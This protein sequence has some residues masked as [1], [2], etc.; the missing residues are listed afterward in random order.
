MRA[1]TTSEIE[2]ELCRRSLGEF[3][4]RFFPIVE[5]GRKYERTIA[6]ELI[7]DRLERVSRGEIK[8]LVINVPPRNAKSVLVSVLWPAWDWIDHPGRRFLYA[9]HKLSLTERDSGRWRDLIEHPRYKEMFD[10]CFA[11]SASQN[12]KA[13]IENNR[14][15]HRIATS[16]GAS[17]TGE[18]GDFLVIDDPHRAKDAWSPAT[19]QRDREWFDGTMT[20]R[21]N[22][23]AE[24]AFVFSGQR[25][26][27]DDLFARALSL[28]GVNH[29]CL[30]AQFDPDHRFRTPDDPRTEPGQLLW[31][32]RFDVDYIEDL[33]AMLGPHGAAAQL[34]QQPSPQRGEIF[35]Q[36]WWR[37]YPPHERPRI[38]DEVIMSWDT[39]LSGAPTADYTA[40]QAWGISGQDRYLLKEVH[41]RLTLPEV[42][43]EIKNLNNWVLEEYPRHPYP[44]I[45]IEAAAIGKGLAE[46]LRS[47]IPTVA[48]V[49]VS[50]G[51]VQRAN[52]V[53]PL[54]YAG[55]V[56]LPG[57]ANETGDGFDPAQTP[58]FVQEFIHE[59][60]LFR[61][62]CAHDDRV[63][64]ATQALRV[65][66]APGPR[67]YVLQA[68]Y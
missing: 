49:S 33:K 55:H 35:E 4:E 39:S 20:T 54:I 28:P 59:H 44:T 3:V 65:L 50:D 68:P 7:I 38:L 56:Y 48:L 30:P 31:P 8:K 10:D 46:I 27:E 32:E 18:G 25:I 52:A 12:S 40:G 53:L 58:T 34:Q 13:R 2:R 5:P 26:H 51:K 1:P 60:T 64:A 6:A 66:G 21:M 37:Y 57:A 62:G 11:L 29:L 22:D 43:K 45:Y 24:G 16:V 36:R 19:L 47:E 42:L 15:G 41:A 23:P 9:S 61:E 17:A 63:D 67:I 14:G